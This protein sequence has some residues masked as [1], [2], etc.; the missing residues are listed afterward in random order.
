MFHRMK[1][2]PS[3]IPF[4]HLVQDNAPSHRYHNKERHAAELPHN[5]LY[6]NS[7]FCVFEDQSANNVLCGS[8]V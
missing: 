7:I 4:E 6:V 1:K 8:V 2:S 3:G 5:Y